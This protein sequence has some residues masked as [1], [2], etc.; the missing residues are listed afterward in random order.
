M[1][2]IVIGLA[3]CLGLSAC[4]GVTETRERV[5][6]VNEAV[7]ILQA[8]D[9][10][11]AWQLL[12]DALDDLSSAQTPFSATIQVHTS[13]TSLTWQWQVD[14]DGD[15]RLDDLTATAAPH[16]YLLSADSAQVYRL[17]A[18][19]T[20]CLLDSLTAE[21]VRA[22]L[23]GLLEHAGLEQV[24]TQALAVLTAPQDV[25]VAERAATRY[26]LRARLPDA[27]AL[28]EAYG[29]H[30]ASQARAVSQTVTLSGSVTRDDETGALLELEVS[31]KDAQTGAP[32]A[33]QFI[34]T[35]WGA[36]PDIPRPD[37]ITPCE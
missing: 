1:R 18:Q 3:V 21:S 6:T 36:V 9:D 5:N 32:I 37:A 2:R 33:L 26:E 8:V 29:D 22:G 13:S 23:R 14:A 34:V 16:S 28:L 17:D 30:N 11:D 27:V 7:A 35:R 24:S 25:R 10:R 20:A 31:G 19:G 12:N 4:A 15:Q